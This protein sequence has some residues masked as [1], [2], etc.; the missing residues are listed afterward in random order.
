MYYYYYVYST[1]PLLPKSEILKPLG[2]FCGCTAPFV[3]D[4]VGNPEDSFFRDK[5]QLRS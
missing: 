4:L 5:A 3:L 2:I 1:I